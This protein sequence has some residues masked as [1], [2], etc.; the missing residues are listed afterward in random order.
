MCNKVTHEKA[1]TGNPVKAFLYT[2]GVRIIMLN[3]LI[4]I[5]LSPKNTNERELT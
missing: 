2:S 1:F 4:N 5:F 3:S